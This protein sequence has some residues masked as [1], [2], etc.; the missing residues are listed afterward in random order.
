M[1]TPLLCALV[2]L[3]LF[4]AAVLAD[5]AAIEKTL[6]EMS[7]A[8]EAADVEGYLSHVARADPIWWKEQQNWAKDL[9]RRK[10]T[11]VEF[12]IAEPKEEADAK[13]GA[14]KDDKKPARVEEFGD[15][16]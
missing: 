2:G 12:S 5:R 4:P 14:K 8:A 3:T 10:P 13:D 11:I 1:R 15:K 7:K 16:V 9:V 6:A